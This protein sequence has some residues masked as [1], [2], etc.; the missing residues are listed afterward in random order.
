MGQSS[1]TTY[2]LRDT[3]GRVTVIRRHHP[4]EGRCLEVT[5]A[6]KSYLIVRLPDTST[7]RIERTWTDADGPPTPTAR[8]VDTPLTAAALRELVA[9]VDALK[10][11]SGPAGSSPFRHEPYS[12]PTAE[13]VHAQTTIP[14]L[15]RP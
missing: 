6:G 5:S 8:G 12:L 1:Q 13:D 15:L 11:R 14:A 7:L 10:R 9:I 3:L 2:H 4:L